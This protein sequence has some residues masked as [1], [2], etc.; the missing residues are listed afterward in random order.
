MDESLRGELT[1]RFLHKNEGQ[2]KDRCAA[3]F[4]LIYGQKLSRI[5][6]LRRTDI[7]R[8]DSKILVQLG[9]RPIELPEP[10]AELLRRSLGSEPQERG[11]ASAISSDWVFPG[12]LPGRH[13]T[14]ESLGSRLVKLGLPTHRMRRAALFVLAQQIPP[15]IL[16]TM[17]GISP[18]SAA[19]WTQLA[20]GKWAAY[21]ADRAALPS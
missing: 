15:A 10:F 13:V 14:P 5:A 12:R 1:L 11:I 3:L 2:L 9:D 6:R 16:T 8:L 21:I 18:Y 4:V 19:S 20:Q 7:T 17:L